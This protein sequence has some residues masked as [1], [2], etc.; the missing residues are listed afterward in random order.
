VAKQSFAG[1]LRSQAGAWERAK[2]LELENE[3]ELGKEKDGGINGSFLRLERVGAL[4]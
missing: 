4:S 1:N 3:L 2:R